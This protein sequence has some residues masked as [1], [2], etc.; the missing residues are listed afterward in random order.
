MPIAAYCEI[1]AYAQS[2]YIILE[3]ETKTELL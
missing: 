2:Q 3:I 1:V